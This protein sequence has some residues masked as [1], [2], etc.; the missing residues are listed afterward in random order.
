MRRGTHQRSA[1]QALRPPSDGGSKTEK[2]DVQ[3]LSAVIRGEKWSRS[4]RSGVQ[5]QRILHADKILFTNPTAHESFRLHRCSVP[6]FWTFSHSSF[7]RLP[8]EP[9][10]LRRNLLEKPGAGVSGCLG[11][12]KPSC[13]CLRLVHTL[14]TDVLRQHTN[15]S[16]FGAAV[17]SPGG[18]RRGAPLP[19]MGCGAVTIIRSDRPHSG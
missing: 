18:S 2:R 3:P 17:V 6:F 19:V 7:P 12:S 14:P 13:R 5:S 1:P 16:I 9:V 15:G 4:S 10:Q 11:S 8:R